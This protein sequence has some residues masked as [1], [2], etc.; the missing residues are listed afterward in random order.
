MFK[1]YALTLAVIILFTSSAFADE[2]T[3]FC[4]QVVDANTLIVSS[5]GN[6][7]KI[8]LA[9]IDAPELGQ[10]FGAEA[11]QFVEGLALNQKLKIF[12]VTTKGKVITAEAFSPKKQDPINRELVRSGLAWPII[13]KDKKHPYDL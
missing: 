9:Y 6:T 1:K 12:P 11:K 13:E 7:Y 4:N 2:I 5:N 8:I 3:G 10:K